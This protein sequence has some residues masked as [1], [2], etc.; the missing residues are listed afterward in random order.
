M[1]MA[2]RR[3]GAARAPNAHNVPGNAGTSTLAMPTA[4][5]SKA[6]SIGPAPPNGISVISLACVPA[7]ASSCSMGTSIPL[8]AT[9]STPSAK[10]GKVRPSFSANGWATASD[11]AGSGMIAP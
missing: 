4:S 9:R 10:A 1:R 11:K 6:P 5:A 7:R 8:I 2:S 3:I